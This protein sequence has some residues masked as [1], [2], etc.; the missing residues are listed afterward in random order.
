VKGKNFGQN[1]WDKKCGAIGNMFLFLHLFVV[2][3]HI[4][5]KQKI[6][7]KTLETT[8]PFFLKGNFVM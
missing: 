5:Y 7:K 8:N 4:G 6:L 2:D 3:C 1:T